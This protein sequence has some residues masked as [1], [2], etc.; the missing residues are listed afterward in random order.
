MISSYVLESESVL[1][2][3]FYYY[4]LRDHY[5]TSRKYDLDGDEKTNILSQEKQEI[6]SRLNKQK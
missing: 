4:Y 2:P 6:L 3:S 5:M 1:D